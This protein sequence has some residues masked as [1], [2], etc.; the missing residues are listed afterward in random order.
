MIALG[1]TGELLDNCILYGRIIFLSMP[2]FMLQNVFQ[3]FFV[4]AE[5]PKLGLTV[6]VLAGVTNMILGFL[7]ICGIWLGHCR[8]G[9]CDG[10]RG[11]CR[12]VTATGIFWKEKCKPVPAGKDKIILEYSW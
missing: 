3:C 4:T 12:R 8:G 7:F 2:A 5:R 9:F 10:M 1:A 6:I 11:V